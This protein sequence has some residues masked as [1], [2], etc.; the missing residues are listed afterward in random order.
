MR[1]GA[2][3]ALLLAAGRG[4]RFGGAK[5]LA[6]LRGRPLVAHP[7]ACIADAVRAGTLA[8]GVAVVPAGDDALAGFVATAGLE[9]I[10]NPAPETGLASS[11]RL[12][13][14]AI[15]RHADAEA[16]VILLGDQPG[17]SPELLA[18]LVSAWRA[19]PRPVVRPAWS[20]APGEPGH[21]IVVGRAL[22]GRAAALAGD[23][24]L[25]PLLAAEPSL[26]QDLPVPGHNPDVDTAADLAALE[27]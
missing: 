13:L 5:L 14:A 2:A 11:L 9:A 17:V 25:G 6:P 18:R 23:R 4:T 12:G 19:S 24:G 27:D 1:P 10:P 26:V 20:A 21:P 3:W 22:W 16:A 7:L 8:G 15:A